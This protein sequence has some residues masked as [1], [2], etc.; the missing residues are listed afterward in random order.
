[1]ISPDRPPYPGLRPFERDETHLFFGRDGCVDQMIT[2]LAERRFLAVLG[3]S[4]TGKSSLVKTGLLSGLEMG[5]LPGAGSQW[6]IVDF[7][8]GGN[9]LG[10]LARALL[11]V[12]AAATKKLPPDAAAITFL[13]TRFRHEGPRELIKWCLNDNLPQHTNLLLLVDQFEELFRYQN[14]GDREVTQAFVSLLL[15][16]RW[17]RGAVSPR[18]AE[19]PIFV[20]LTMR[21]E[22]LGACALI[23]GLAEAINE[24]T[25]LIPRMRRRDLEEAIVGP[26][27]VCGVT[28][29]RRLV[30]R[31]LN[32]L[33]D[34]AP[35]DEGES[36]DQ[37]SRLARRADQLPLMQHAL[38]HMWRRACE[39][40]DPGE[41]LTLK[42]ADYRGLQQELDDHAEKLYR[43]LEAPVKP[44]A[45]CVF[46]AVTSGTTA[47]NAVRRPTSYG[48]LVEI[49]GPG[50][51]EI[52]TEAIEAFGPRGCQFLT[53]D[54]KQNGEQLPGDAS[55]D[56]AHESLIRQ[57]K[58][59]ARW[60]ESEGRD[61]NEWR[62]L[63]E[64][65]ARRGFLSGRDLS[66]AA[67]L[68]K[69]NPTVAW[70][71]RYG[72]DFDKVIRLIRASERVQNALRIAVAVVPII[73]VAI[74]A[75][76]YVNMQKASFAT[77]NFEL[78]VK[79]TEK[80]LN[81]VSASLAHGDV[82][83]N[84]AKDIIHV[85]RENVVQVK[86]FE[87]TAETLGLL[88]HL[89]LTVSDMYADLG[90]YRFAYANAKNANDV[91]HLLLKKHPDD[92]KALQYL[93]GSIWR[94]ADANF[95][96]GTDQTSRER[97]LAEYRDAERIARRLVELAP[98]DAGH[99]RALMFIGTKIGDVQQKLGDFDGAVAT[100]RAALHV[101][102]KVAAGDPKNHGWRR[103]V[104]TTQRRIAQ[105]LAAKNDFDG[106]IDG[107]RAAIGML[108]GLE[109]D[110]DNVT[111]SNLATTRRFLAELYARREDWTNAAAEYASA[112][113]IHERLL[114]ADPDHAT[115]QYSL[116]PLY[117]G[118]AD[119]LRWQGD[120]PGALE[121][122]RKAYAIRQGL[123]RKD[124]S[125]PAR[126][127][128]LARAAIAVADL[129][130]AQ[131]STLDEAVKLYRE[132]IEIQDEARPEHDD[133]VFHSYIKIGDIRLSQ[134]D[135]ENAF[136]EYTRAWSI[137]HDFTVDDASSLKWQRNLLISHTKIG[138][139]LKAQ[140]NADEAI[141]QQQIA[142]EIATALAVKYPKNTEWPN[143]VELLKVKI[144]ELTQP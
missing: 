17:P 102:E 130:E 96:R 142:L 119:I 123:A 80:V 73:L 109:R 95:Y 36:K 93:Y 103:D 116:A 7:R 60:L 118:M 34:F 13:Q 20:A 41:A 78:A 84:G 90:D 31:L 76:L 56:I 126:R 141:K 59:L 114:A 69:S 53:S 57:W 10:H 47:A 129:L 110:A 12:D 5:L 124:P 54:I 112:I 86:E 115:W 55:I 52:V 132:A 4:G 38:N 21:S 42:L 137:A 104:S 40:R 65:A 107:Y 32:D 50:S 68:R 62:R 113:E 24:G 98:A 111:K 135:L 66:I 108:A 100:Y 8:P 45:E 83:V 26:A 70:A 11:E 105:V 72:G 106:A 61:A 64:S 25:Y 46:R 74:A 29:E 49:C 136:T 131:K 19:L 117:T 91:A 125:S 144:Q 48:D 37:L 89:Q 85:L 28:I 94:M 23:Q 122:A 77:R 92:P 81:Q 67:A 22:Y 87:E 2:R 63:R 97:A 140:E 3:S 99:Q 120:L 133:D 15:E 101:I 121:Q 1:V 138:D 79:S 139:T 143:Q 14:D 16:S 82:T 71:Q 33:A 43:S 88:A 35:W 39:Q 9:S 44:V 134:N 58:R 127:D 51:R 30:N 75:F 18:A 128:S 6:R 27:R